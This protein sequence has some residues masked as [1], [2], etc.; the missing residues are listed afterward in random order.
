LKEPESGGDTRAVIQQR[1]D[2]LMEEHSQGRKA[3]EQMQRQMQRQVQTQHAHLLR[4]E[5]G[6]EA[7]QALLET[8]PAAPAVTPNGGEISQ[9]GSDGVELGGTE[10]AVRQRQTA[11]LHARS[12]NPRRDQAERGGRVRPKVEGKEA[13][14][15]GSEAA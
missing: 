11:P 1:I 7:M 14:G 10:D 8:L 6:I 2:A 12:S 5:G 9:T 13:S 4:L 3:L 15:N